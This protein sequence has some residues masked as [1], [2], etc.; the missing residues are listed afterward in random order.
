MSLFRYT[1]LFAGKSGKQIKKHILNSVLKMYHEYKEENAG[2]VNC[3]IFEYA[4]GFESRLMIE[5]HSSKN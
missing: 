2:A 5:N 3:N 1:P 4:L